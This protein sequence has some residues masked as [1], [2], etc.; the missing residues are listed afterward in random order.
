M[1]SWLI[2]KDPDAGRDWRWEEKGVT[3]DEMVGWH[4]RL[5]GHEFE[6]VPGDSEGQGSLVCC[7][8]WG[9]RELDRTEGLNRNFPH[10]DVCFLSHVSF[11]LLFLQI[12]NFSG[13]FTLPFPSGFLSYYTWHCTRDLLNYHHFQKFFFLLCVQLGWLSLLCLPARWSIPLYH[14][15]YY[16]FLPVYFSFQLFCPSALLGSSLCF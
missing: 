4:Y 13:A 5:N 6:Q 9:R 16:W 12:S 14:L 7:S 1:K 11:Q 2:R 3:E 15:I 10:L 8:P